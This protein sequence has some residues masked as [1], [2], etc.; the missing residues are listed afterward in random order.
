MRLIVGLIVVDGD[1]DNDGND[2]VGDDDTVDGNV[3]NSVD[4]DGWC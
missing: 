4:I 3:Y 2:G 1:V